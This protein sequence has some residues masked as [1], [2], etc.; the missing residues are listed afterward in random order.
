MK[1]RIYS[2]RI[3]STLTILLLL[4]AAFPFSTA[5]A[6]STGPKNPGDGANVATT[7]TAA[8]T[9]PGNITT[10][11][12]PYATALIGGGA[13]TNYLQATNYNFAIPS[14]STIN[15]I[16]VAINR[17]ASGPSPSNVSDNVVNLI[18]GGSVTGN[19]KATGTAWPVS[20][21]TATYGGSADLWGSSW[22]AANIN[23]TDFGVYLSAYNGNVGGTRDVTVDTIQVTVNYTL[24]DTTTTVNCGSGTPVVTYGSN[25]TCV[26]SVTRVAGTNT[27]SGSVS[28]TTGGSGSF[29]TSPCTLSGSSGTATCSV[30]YTPSAVGSGSHLITA[31]YSGEVNFNGSSGNQTVTVNKITP[32]LS[33]SNTP[34]A[35]TGSPISATVIGSIEGAVSKIRYGGSAAIP[36]EVGTYAVTADFI[37]TDT[38][39]YNSL[40]SA[41]AGSFV[42]QKA[43]PTLTVTNSPV[44]FNGSPQ[45]ATVIGS[46]AGTVSG[47][48]YNGSL[49]APINAGTYAV[50]ANFTPTD[51]AHYN[52]LTLAPAG[53][54]LINKAAPTL[55]VTN[56]PVIYNTLPQ[57][58]AVTGSVT[59]TVSNIRYGGSLTVPTNVA[60]Y[61]ITAD[62]TSSNANYSDLSGAPAG[63]FVIN[64]AT[65]TLSVTNSPVTYNASPQAAT[66]T[67]S[68]AGSIG[69]IL[70]GGSPTVPTNAATYAITADF[71][72][73]DTVNYNS[74]TAASAGNF[75][76]NKATPT[77]VVAN[78]PVTYNGSPFTAVVN[79]SVAGTV[80]N[81]RYDG[82]LTEPTNA[83]TYAI[84]ANFAPTDTTNYNTLTSAS[85]G[86]FVINKATPTLS[87]TNS[88]VIY[89]ASPQAATVNA[90]VTGTVT[91]IRYDGSATIPTNAGTYAITADFTSGNANYS[92]LSGAAAGNFVINKA[93][94]TLSISNTP[95]SYTG[96]PIPAVVIG[97]VPGIASNI[98]YAGLTPA[99]TEIGTYAVTADFAPTDT[100]NYNGLIGASAGNFVIQKATPILAVTNSPVTFNGAPQA[101]ALSNS[102]PG[103]ISNVRYGGSLTVPTDAGTYAITANFAP[104]DTAHYNTLTG[105]S[106]GNFVIN[107]ATPTLSVT[108]SPVT[109]NTSPQAATVTGSVTGTVTNIRYDGSATI[110]TNAGTYAITADFT[111]SNAN[112]SDLSGAAAGNFVID[113]ATPTLSI[114]NTPASYTG[115]PIPA[116][117]IGNV[118]G[119]ASNILYVSLAP[120]PAEIGTYAVTADFAPTDTANYNG[121]IGASAGNFVI[122]KANPVLAVTNSPVTYNGAPQAA[123]LSISVP[124]TISNVLYGGSLTVPTN[125]GT[126]AITA[127]FAPTDTAHY[128]TLTG[129]SAGNFLINKV[130][131]TLSVTNSPVIYN[132]SPQA[133]TVSGSVAG[134][135]TNIRYS[136]SA[137]IPTNVATYTVTADFTPTD[138]TNYN[139]LTSA[140]A[141]NFVINKATPTLVVSNSPVIYNGS[142]FTALVTPS[143]AGVISN[144]KY[145]G[146]TTK[147]T[148]VGTY[149]ITAD[150]TPTDTVNYNNVTNAFAGNFVINKATPTLSVTNSPAVFDS[151]PH[152]ATVVGSVPGVVSNILYNGSSTAPTNVGTYAVTANFAP[153]DTANY[154]SLTLA[155]AGNFVITTPNPVL[156]LV[157]TY[158]PTANFDAG[159]IIQYNYT[160]TNSGN[161]PLE[162]PFTVT[163]NRVAVTC[164]TT[165]SLAL[166]ASITCSAN[167]TLTLV[168]VNAGF[169]TNTAS[170]S[171]RYAGNPV[172]SNSASVTIRFYKLFGPVITK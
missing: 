96:A 114:S 90:S 134:T 169:V 78:S 112:Y 63:N 9:G 87:V 149:A 59:G 75:V 143:T 36:T 52:S 171:A 163:D 132:A 151:Q 5:F 18:R 154:F 122:Q 40:T 170:A 20:L 49:T 70:Y 56:S 84:T 136:G 19:N 105:A 11:G 38:A 35:Y 101:A 91:N 31:T 129:A 103:T 148:N 158:T 66:I 1:N 128:N 86:N 113:K 58:A 55:S 15:G 121:L 111:S 80:T 8:W 54:F 30:T 21:E 33:I 100:A 51:T 64:K 3:V 93:T 26:A 98:L 24:P 156:S 131:P 65:P 165:S 48:R 17:M 79:G 73:T 23:G 145:S 159:D 106:A 72:P 62:F 88:P 115:A 76:I 67:S 160:L 119:I 140:T 45:A 41:P 117:V 141:G 12:S 60:T 68:V 34:A 43:T 110:P 25:I 166:A 16:T 120:P 109:Y 14:G 133:A 10:A 127:D 29:T 155:S 137:T 39:N 126:Y 77:L 157:K 69:N 44:T 46:V 42:I 161:V 85:A 139:S 97:N 118:P 94:P 150:F 22:T 37:P 130:T 168:D 108:N 7:G 116:V 57:A 107:K 125:A 82:S 99:P 167:Y 95:A 4:M 153:A 13:T 172:P 135:V 50:S 162:G 92:D 147:P 28:W 123:A 104:T 32:T 142:P 6:A 74:L 89:N 102:V 146:A 53:N 144:I 2:L 124:G 152:A 164:P 83:S 81:I 71:V 47:I 138:L 27:P 61:A